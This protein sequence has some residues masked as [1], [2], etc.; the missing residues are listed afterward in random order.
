MLQAALEKCSLLG[1]SMRKTF[2]SLLCL[3]GECTAPL[4]GWGDVTEALALSQDMLW[5][6]LTEEQ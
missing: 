4:D 5:L 1:M 6:R 2:V 3:R